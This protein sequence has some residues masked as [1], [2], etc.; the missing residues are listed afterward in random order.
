MKTPPIIERIKP[1]ID[2]FSVIVAV[3][4]IL[5]LVAQTRELQKQNTVIAET[6]D[7]T[8]RQDTFDKSLSFDEFV[9]EHAQLY[10]QVTAAPGEPGFVANPVNAA[11]VD[12]AAI[13]IMDFYDYI[14]LD[15]STADYSTLGTVSEA[16]RSEN[17]A[18]A[19]GFLAWSNSVAATF[20]AGS[21]LCKIFKERSTSYG[22]SSFVRR[23]ENAG[24]CGA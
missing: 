4:G 23:I 10:E 8:Y 2:T 16:T 15:Y 13:H 5:I 9:I 11:E 3:A 1:W 14:L 24:Y 20:R 6:L 21:R 19:E 18:K 12:A 17:P 7:Q 22:T